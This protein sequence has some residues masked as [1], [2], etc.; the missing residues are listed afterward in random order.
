MTGAGG[1]D[2]PTK[3]SSKSMHEL[4]SVDGLNFSSK[5]MPVITRGHTYMT[6]AVG[7]GGGSP[8]SRQKELGCVNSVCDR[9]ERGS[10]N[11]KT[12]WTSY[13]YRPLAK[14]TYRLTGAYNLE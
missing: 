13:K 1:Q 2:H 8:K 6:S 10:K 3:I 11:P 5:C 12:L 14:E 4:R 7:G 9:G